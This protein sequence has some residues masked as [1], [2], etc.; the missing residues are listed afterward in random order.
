M[1]T[2]YDAIIIGTG[3]A[4]RGPAGEQRIES[5]DHRTQAIRRHLREQRLHP[6][7]DAGRKRPRSTYGT[8]RGRVWR[9]D[10]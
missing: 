5:C 1:G 7:E 8:T 9:D 3:Q 2:T 10:R 4:G 6:N